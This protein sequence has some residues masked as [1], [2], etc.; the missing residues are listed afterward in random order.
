MPVHKQLHVF[1]SGRVQGVGFRYTAEEAALS[2]G[3]TGWVR[4]LPDGRV[5]AVCEGPKRRLERFLAVIAAGPMRP[6]IQSHTADWGAAT[7][8]FTDFRVRFF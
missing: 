1:W 7:G 6:N 4:N 5:E 3:L 2:L 8:R